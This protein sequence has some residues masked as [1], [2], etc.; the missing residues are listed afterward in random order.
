MDTRRARE[1][2]WGTLRLLEGS[3]PASGWSR[4]GKQSRA[5]PFS[6]GQDLQIAA[7]VA[8]SD[9]IKSALDIKQRVED[10]ADF[11]R[12]VSD[13]QADALTA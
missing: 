12:C 4:L 11:R 13:T 2:H 8:F 7:D 5:L 1:T 9:I 3:R 10:S 6:D